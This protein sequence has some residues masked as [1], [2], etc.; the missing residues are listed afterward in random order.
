MTQRDSES[1]GSNNVQKVNDTKSNKERTDRDVEKVKQ[2]DDDETADKDDDKE[3]YSI[4]CCSFM[5]SIQ[6][7][8]PQK[9]EVS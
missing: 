1:N 5:P 6:I 4:Q 2:P 3:K 9:P 8:I 7:S